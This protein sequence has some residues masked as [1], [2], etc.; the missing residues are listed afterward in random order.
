MFEYIRTKMVEDTIYRINRKL[1]DRACKSS[2]S[3]VTLSE[4]E[5]ML[6]SAKGKTDAGQWL[7]DHYTYAIPFTYEQFE[8]AVTTR[9]PKVRNGHIFRDQIESLF[10]PLYNLEWFDGD[11]SLMRQGFESQLKVYEEKFVSKHMWNY[12]KLEVTKAF[13][14]YFK[15]SDD[16]M[17]KKVYLY[18]GKAG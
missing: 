18:F 5:L 10:Y 1:V 17:G 9:V 16:A 13:I 7:L 15:L 6:R 14:D 4:L 11:Q 12:T 8:E 3:T 2:A